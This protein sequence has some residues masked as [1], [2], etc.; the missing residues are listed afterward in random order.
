MQVSFSV[1]KNKINKSGLMPV[2]MTITFKGE[3][4]RKDVKD[5]RVKEKHWKAKDQRIKPSTKSEEYNY[6]V[7]YNKK[8]DEQE[9]VVKSIFRYLMLNNIEPTKEFVLDKLNSGLEV[10]LT[11]D[12]V[13]CF[14]EF[15]EKG[16]NIKTDGTLRRYRTALNFYKDFSEAKNFRLHFDNIT[17]DF[18]EDFRDY[19]FEERNTLNNYFAKLVSVLKTFMNWSFDRGYHENIAYQKF[20]APEQEI[21]VVYLTMEELMQLYK[22]EFESPRLE[23]T[24]DTYCFGCFSGLR[25]SD[26]KQLNSSHVFDDYIKLNIQKTKR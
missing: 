6:H 24:K 19:A 5:V 4:V 25:Y 17:I 7:E 2:L 16:K 1:R 15:I 11:H 12:F 23:H 10:N 3:R 9:G 22:H 8:L 21:E 14:E 26:L 20:K 18:F 13:D